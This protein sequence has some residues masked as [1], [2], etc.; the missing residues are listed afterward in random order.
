MS[1][2]PQSIEES[3]NEALEG[4][5]EN[6]A[7]QFL[8]QGRQQASTTN[9]CVICSKEATDFRDAASRKEYQ[10]S[11]MCQICQDNIFGV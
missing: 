2:K 4:M 8:S 11:R 3:K 10:I 5:L 1:T 9:T 6:F 7:Q